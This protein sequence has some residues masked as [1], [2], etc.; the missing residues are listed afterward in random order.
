MQRC[1]NSFREDIHLN[2]V[3]VSR[4]FTRFPETGNVPDKKKTGQLCAECRRI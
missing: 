3:A 1:K 4:V 2:K